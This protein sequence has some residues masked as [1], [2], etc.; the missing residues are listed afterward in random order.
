LEPDET[1]TREIGHLRVI[2]TQENSTVEQQENGGRDGIRTRHCF[3]LS[4]FPSDDSI[5]PSI[6]TDILNI[7]FLIT[8][9]PA[10][11]AELK[12]STG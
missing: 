1:E 7:N 10:G 6:E 2:F 12:N 5:N 3:Y 9:T 11:Q 8:L 4:S